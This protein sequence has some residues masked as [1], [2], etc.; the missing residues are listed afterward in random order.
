MLEYNAKDAVTE[1]WPAG[2]YPAVLAAVEEKQSKSSGAWMYVVTFNVYSGAKARSLKS[3]MVLGKPFMLRALSLGLGAYDE[4]KADRFDPARYLN[5]NVTLT[6]AVEDSPEYGAQNKITGFIAKGEAAATPAIPA[7]AMK[8]AK[9]APHT[10][11]AMR[12]PGDDERDPEIP[13]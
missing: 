7:A 12:E 9:S 13:F 11:A 3:Y 4:F 2:N 8:A 1:P 10:P 6:L 5:D